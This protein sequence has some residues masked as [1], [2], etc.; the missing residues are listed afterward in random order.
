MVDDTKL[1]EYV[2]TQKLR[3]YCHVLL[4][5]EVMGNK[6]KAAELSGVS[7]S[8]F[9]Y[10]L[11]NHAAFPEWFKKQCADAVLSYLPQICYSTVK[12]AMKGDHSAQKTLLEMAGLFRPTDNGIP[13]TKVEVNIHPDRT[14]IVQDK[15][16]EAGTDDEET[17][18]KSLHAG[19]GTGGNILEET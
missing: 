17:A 6:E 19:E 2:P 11:K 12:T 9:Y 14:F 7:K 13:G 3:H 5:K 15:L 18:T 8:L 4:S 16:I 1:H 10:T